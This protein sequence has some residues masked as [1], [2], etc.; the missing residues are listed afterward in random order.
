MKLSDFK[1]DKNALRQYFNNKVG[2]NKAFADLVAIFEVAIN[3]DELWLFPNMNGATNYQVYLDKWI[4]LYV[5]AKQRSPLTVEASP[6]TSA[7]DLSVS[8]IVK[9]ARKLTDEEVEQMLKAHNLFMSAENTQGYLLEEYI[10]S[11]IVPHG[12]LYCAGNLLHAVDFCSA[13]GKLLLQIKNKSNSENIDFLA[14]MDRLDRDRRE[15]DQ[16]NREER[17]S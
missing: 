12:F 13:D 2:A 1:I 4:A 17:R 3:S 15:S 11:V 8:Q 6:K 10:A 16:R 7:S 14:Y 9:T 5:K